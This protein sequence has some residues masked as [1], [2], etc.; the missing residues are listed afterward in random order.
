MANTAEAIPLIPQKSHEFRMRHF[1]GDVFDTSESS[2]LFKFIAAM[3]GDAGAGG[4][5]KD[6]FKKRLSTLI[7]SITFRDLD[8]LFDG[9]FGIPRFADETYRYDTDYDLLTSDEWDEIMAKDAM[10][11]ERCTKFF[12]ALGA[13]GT[14][15]GVRL[16]AE[17]V[18]GAPCKIFEVWRYLD[19]YGFS[20]RSQNPNLLIGGNFDNPLEAT[21][22]YWDA[23][24]ATV[25]HSSAS[26]AAT[27]TSPYAGTGFMAVVASDSNPKTVTSRT[28]VG[29]SQGRQHTASVVVFPMV[30]AQK[31]T[32]TLQFFDQNDILLTSKSAS[33]DAGVS[34]WRLL[35]VS[36]T[37]PEKTDYL[38]IEIK[39]DKGNGF[40][41]DSAA[42]VDGLTPFDSQLDSNVRF[43][44]GGG[45]WRNEVVLMPKVPGEMDAETFLS[46]KSRFIHLVDRIKPQDSIVTVD[47][48]GLRQSTKMYIRG[49]GADSEYF[50]VEKEVTGVIDI[51]NTPKDSWTEDDIVRTAWW[52]AGKTTKAPVTAFG[53]T[54]E[55]SVYYI[56][57]S[58]EEQSID[59]V[60]YTTQEPS[61]EDWH[62]SSNY[63][64][65]VDGKKTKTFEPIMA[66][67]LTVPV[68]DSTVTRGWTE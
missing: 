41:V 10:Y 5:K 66:V 43:G 30:Q 12:A 63:T 13:G 4:L 62:E 60:K 6:V 25:M 61:G 52:E 26:S 49:V 42:I 57:G 55:D 22:D 58:G 18:W 29:S 65:V 7:S 39:N 67:P 27:G 8:K 37:S 54:M 14:P 1:D 45:S 24:G 15:E 64:Q 51:N 38:K 21:K 19:N 68:R 36:G 59:S 56:A 46:R 3:C 53:S 31:F 33:F 34:Q 50:E 11:R 32:I 16:A 20:S 44:R 2:H 9:G 47:P 23:V 28:H 35:N 40:F 48:S 17:A